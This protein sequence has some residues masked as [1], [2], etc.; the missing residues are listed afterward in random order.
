MF[1]VLKINEYLKSRV[2]AKGSF[3]RLDTD[4]VDFTS[5]TP[6]FYALKHVALVVAK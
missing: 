5:L 1:M 4:K 2:V 6:D 3:Q